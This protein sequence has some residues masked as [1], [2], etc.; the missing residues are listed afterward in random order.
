M[1]PLCGKH[2]AERPSEKYAQV[3][4]LAPDQ[5][6]HLT[7]I[8]EWTQPNKRTDVQTDTTKI[9]IIIGTVWSITVTT[10]SRLSRTISHKCSL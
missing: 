1:A 7:G 9:V 4:G 5:V 3:L 10:L 8:A 2:S 6:L